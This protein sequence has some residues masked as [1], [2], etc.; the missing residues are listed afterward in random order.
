MTGHGNPPPEGFPGGADDEYR[1]T[2]FDE[3]FVRAARLQEFSARERLAD[4]EHP[5]RALP[6]GPLRGLPWQGLVL[7]LLIVMAFGAAVYLGARAPQEPVEPPPGRQVMHSTV[8]PLAPRGQVPGGAP[9]RLFE[10]SPAAEFYDGASGVSLPPARDTAHFAESQVLAALTVAKEYLVE[11]S[12]NPE[13][14][15]GSTER[16]VRILLDPDQHPQ[17]DRSLREPADDGR[18][19]ATGWLVRFDPE[20]TALTGEGVRVRGTMEYRETDAAALE[21]HTDHVFVYAVRPAEGGTD[22]GAGASLFTVR[23]ELL[24]RFD[25]EDLRDHHL[26]VERST[27]RAGPMECTARPHDVLVPLTAGQRAGNDRPADT[28]PYARDGG[29]PVC[30]TLDP[31]ALPTP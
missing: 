30:G 21:V 11:S 26:T 25:R 15:T 6:S 19:A 10:H 24:L 31:G 27:V 5:V 12:V 18:H 16:P 8:V 4:H 23:R 9:E 1:S 29:A 14:L 2:V 22:A 3:S 13:V 20:R 17:F 7:T 28:D